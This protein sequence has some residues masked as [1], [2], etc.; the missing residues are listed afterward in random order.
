MIG[1]MLVNSSP[2]LTQDIMHFQ[3]TGVIMTH[4]KNGLLVS[5]GEIKLTSHIS[6]VN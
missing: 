3:D 6:Q 4:P 1:Y 2:G 5:S